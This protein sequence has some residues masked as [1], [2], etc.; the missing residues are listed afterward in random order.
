MHILI[1][2][3]GAG[4]VRGYK[5]AREHR[6]A[7]DFKAEY[8]SLAAS[9]AWRNAH[10]AADLLGANTLQVLDFPDSRFDGVDIL[11]LTHA[12]EAAIDRVRPRIVYTHYPGD[13]SVDHRRTSEAVITAC[14]PKPGHPV[15]ELYF[16]EVASNTEWALPLTFQPQ[17]FV[18][19]NAGHKADIMEKAYGSEMRKDNHP[20]ER[21]AI[22]H[23]AYNRGS[24]AGLRAAEA[25]MVGRII[26]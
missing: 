26:R 24:Q 16:F 10:K 23:H 15:K 17:M 1:M 8:D 22:L 9:P 14:R 18:Q 21:M 6:Y 11:D 12:V 5:Q 20:R 25:F 4:D 7:G 3:D 13:L 2:T 19:V